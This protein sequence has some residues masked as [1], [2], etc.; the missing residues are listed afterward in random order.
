MAIELLINTPKSGNNEASY[1]EIREAKLVYPDNGGPPT[2]SVSL[3]SWKDL[4]AK[5]N[6][7]GVEWQW[8]LPSLDKPF[9]LNIEDLERGNI[10]NA[11]VERTGSPFYGGVVFGTNS[12]SIEVARARKWNEI[13]AEYDRRTYGPL[14]TPVGIID[15]DEFSQFKMLQTIALAQATEAKGLSVNIPWT[16]ADNSIV[17][18]T[19]ADDAISMGFALAQR[20]LELRQ[21]RNELRE[22]INSQDATV[23]QVRAIGW[24]STELVEDTSPPSPTVNAT[25]L[26]PPN[27]AEAP[28]V[29]PPPAP[30]PT[31]E[32]VTT[33]PPVTSPAPPAPTPAPPPPVQN[34][35]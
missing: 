6:G 12:E 26:V 1:H 35:P 32:P 23:A 13:K 19:S 8:T 31:S 24:G 9:V 2:I 18:L 22:L 27:P 16:L 17:M 33:P 5:T 30:A 28:Q 29:P 4:A 14:P 7:G 20:E 25:P 21:R 3:Y 11:L 10:E 34:A 15:A